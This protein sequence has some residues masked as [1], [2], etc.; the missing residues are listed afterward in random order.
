MIIKV[1]VNKPT[2]KAGLGLKLDITDGAHIHIYDVIE[3]GP[4]FHYN[5]QVRDAL[6][7]KAGDFLI[8]VNGIQ[9]D[10]GMIMEELQTK[11]QSVLEI[12]RPELW[13]VR[14]DKKGDESWGLGLSC[15]P[16]TTSL[17]ITKVVAGAAAMWNLEHPGAA[18]KM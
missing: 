12:S 6:Q 10:A 8:S 11:D 18:M 16:H 13:E 1:T 17:V 4:V 7:I 14:L 15:A 5:Q 2:K 3:G 9:G